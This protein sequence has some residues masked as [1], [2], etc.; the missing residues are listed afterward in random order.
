MSRFL[1]TTQSSILADVL[2][3]NVLGDLDFNLSCL[4]LK[5]CWPCANLKGLTDMHNLRSF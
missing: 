1:V 3:N 4:I 5:A 2:C